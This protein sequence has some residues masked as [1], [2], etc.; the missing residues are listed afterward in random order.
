MKKNSKYGIYKNKIYDVSR[1]MRQRIYDREG[2]DQ[3]S[4]PTH[5]GKGFR[6][7]PVKLYS[8][9]AWCAC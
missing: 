2:P 3:P 5:S 8:I 7:M 4:A 9:Q 6:S 1:K